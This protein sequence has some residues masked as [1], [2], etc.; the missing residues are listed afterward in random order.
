[1]TRAMRCLAV[2][3][4]LLPLAAAAEVARVKGG[5][6]PEFTRIVVESAS[7]TDWRFGRTGDGYEL[8]MAGDVTGFDL[9][10]AF[11]KI[12]KDRVSG[13][14]RDPE[15]GRLRIALSCACHAVA[16]EFRPG[17]VVVDVKSGPPPAASSFELPIGSDG[18]QAVEAPLPD[19]VFDNAGPTYDWLEIARDEEAE[20]AVEGTTAPDLEAMAVAAALDPLQEAL[21]EQISRGAAEGIV[22]IAEHPDLPEGASSGLV[23]GEGIRIAIGELP[24]V[25]VGDSQ[26]PGAGLAADGTSC[27]PDERL[28]VASWALPGTVAEQLGP[29]RSGLLTEFD[30]PVAPAVLRAARAYIALGFGA[31]ARQFLAFLDG[32][33]DPEAAILHSLG[34]IID[35]EAPPENAFAGMESC[36][37]AAALWAML[38]AVA[39]GPEAAAALHNLDADAV[40]RAF[41]ALAPHLRRF[42]GPPLVDAFLARG[43]EETAR[44]LRDAI[45]RAPGEAG[46]EV[47]LMEARYDLA[48]GDPEAA[49]HAAG[50]VRAEAGP[51][52]ADALVTQVEAAFLGSQALSADIAQQIEALLHENAGTDR[53]A[54]L[55]RALVLGNALSGDF[56][57]AFAG[58]AAT[59]ATGADLWSLAVSGAGDAL[60]FEEAVTA[61][62]L[63]DPSLRAVARDVQLRAAERLMS[64]GF[65]EEAL[66]WLGPVS[67]TDDPP[68]R[69]L[70][71]AAHLA[72][73]DARAALSDL[74]GLG[75]P[76]AEALRATAVLQLGDPAAAAEA[77]G[78]AGDAEARDRAIVWT[79]DWPI[80]AAEGPETWASAAALLDPQEAAAG[81]AVEGP[82]TPAAAAGEAPPTGSLARGAALVEDSAAT[83]ATIEGLLLS[84]ATSPEQ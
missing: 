53:E 7:A 5:E 36:D 59:P 45:Q 33:E 42:L 44:R 8:D 31:E 4:C 80:L 79:R 77:Y 68:R 57:A 63:A 12:P 29:G 3:L 40:A 78:R 83:R 24:G 22:G 14:W 72:L 13:L 81:L 67:G 75:D 34:H 15:T 56:A 10:V 46:P 30:A 71:A 50:E 48:T 38:A 52:T 73:G 19:A 16:F 23:E 49:L 69:L 20:P 2:I 74:S 65:A 62:R 55:R 70:A 84:I 82:A 61:A 39:T 41:S 21:L 76:E 25:I 51:L 58:L 60:F 17:I 32:D 26:E 6:H 9:S 54:P 11:D 66:V 37:G 18:E 64:L 47:A 1:M 35:G 27:I 43:D 28:Q